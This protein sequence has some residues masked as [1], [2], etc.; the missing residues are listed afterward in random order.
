[1][2]VH[3][4]DELAHEIRQQSG[5]TTPYVVALDGRSGAGKST[6]AQVL[7][8]R[9]AASVID[10]D[11]FYAG[12]TLPDWQK[13]TAQQKAELVIDWR[14]VRRDVLEP[15]R[16][17]QR[18][19]W[20]PFNWAAL[21]GLAP[22][23]LSADPAPLVILDGAYSARP[24]LSDLINLSVLVQLPDAVRRERLQLR[25]GFD[26]TSAWHPVWDEA[27][28]YYFTH[29]RPPGT[30]DIVFDRTEA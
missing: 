15:L 12:G 27:E 29:V 24:E 9:L 20:H 2:V 5:L 8:T 11:D 17:N 6:L 30:F 13:L 10:Q 28:D 23:R 25:E 14:R 18:A 19:V 21:Q 26:Y 3:G 4:V 1:M 22:H 7:A 16:A